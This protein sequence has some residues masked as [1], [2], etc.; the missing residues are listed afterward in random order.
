MFNI[1]LLQQCDRLRSHVW[2]VH[3]V[4]LSWGKVLRSWGKDWISEFS[5][6]APANFLET[7]RIKLIGE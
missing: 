3:T 1:A 5:A 7:T 2:T 6:R 4:R